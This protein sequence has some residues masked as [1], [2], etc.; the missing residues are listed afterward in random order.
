MSSF[1]SHFTNKEMPL[2]QRTIRTR[3]GIALE[4][5]LTQAIPIEGIVTAASA[6]AIQSLHQPLLESALQT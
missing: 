5:G 1:H 3:F 6:N 4:L 2:V